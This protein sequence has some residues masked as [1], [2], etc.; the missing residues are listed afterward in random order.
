MTIDFH[1]HVFPDRIA[2]NALDILSQKCG[3]KPCTDGTV[4]GTSAFMKKRKIDRCVAL[5]TATNEKQMIN[6]NQFAASLISDPT[7]IPF[8]SVYPKSEYAFTELERIAELGLKGIK[9]HP[10][11]QDFEVSDPRCY[12]VV[13]KAAELG[14]VILFHA[15][16]D[17][18]YP[19]R[20]NAPPKDL[21]KLADTF[22]GA[23]LVFAHFGGFALSEDVLENLVGCDAYLDTSCMSRLITKETALAIIKAKGEDKIL[24]GSD[25][26]WED[27]EDSRNLIESLGLSEAVKQAIYSENAERLLAL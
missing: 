27:P 24:F 20:L 2:G 11:Y 19:E 22:K 17:A 1:V 9:L 21:R 15:G 5:S 18:A 8:G 10:E 6:V 25:C 13:E 14:L 16:K 7:Y 4:T 26:P 23:K 3:I 12:R